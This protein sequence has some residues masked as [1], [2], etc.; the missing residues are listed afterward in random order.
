MVNVSI[1]LYKLLSLFNSNM[2]DP[3]LVAT[4]EY[5]YENLHITVLSDW[6]RLISFFSKLEQIIFPYKNTSLLIKIYSNK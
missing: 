4:N 1:Y 2:S 3:I 6:F 5:S